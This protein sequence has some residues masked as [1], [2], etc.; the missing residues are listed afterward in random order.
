MHC[1][2]LVYKLKSGELFERKSENVLIMNYSFFAI[3]RKSN[4]SF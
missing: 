2:F 4:G 1:T 3:Y